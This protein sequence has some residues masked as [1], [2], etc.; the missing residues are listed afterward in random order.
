MRTFEVTDLAATPFAYLT[1]TTEISGISAVMAESFGALGK[2]FATAAAPMTGPPLCHYIAYDGTSTTFQLGFPCRPEDG[3]RLA[4]AGLT[5][6]TTQAGK[7]MK[8]RHVGPYDTV[9]QTYD[10]M[11]DEM[12]SRHLTGAEHMWEV[13]TSPPETPPAE[14]VTEVIWPVSAAA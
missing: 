11:Q 1:R 7:V 4:A 3:E 6:G 2:A 9:A 10:A 13:Y 12:K 14:I 5:L 8:A